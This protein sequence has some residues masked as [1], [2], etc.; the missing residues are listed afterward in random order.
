MDGEEILVELEEIK[1]PW[2]NAAEF[3]AGGY[4]LEIQATHLLFGGFFMA[5]L[6]INA[7]R[8]RNAPLEFRLSTLYFALT[9]Y[10]NFAYKIVG[11]NINEIFGILSTFILLAKGRTPIRMSSSMASRGLFILFIVSSLHNLAIGFAYPELLQDTSAV[12]LKMAVNI[13]IFI[14]AVNMSIVGSSIVRGIGLYRL[15]NTC[16]TAGII[17]QAMYLLQ[18]ALFV[19]GVTPYGTYIDAGFTGVP[20]FGSVSIERGHMGKFIAPY[21]AF[22]LYA[23]IEWKWRWKFA[24]F[25]IASA[26]NFSASG[27]VFFV[28]SII[29]TIIVFNRYIGA[30][31]YMLLGLTLT[32]ILCLIVIYYPVFDGMINKI[33][34]IAING[35]ESQ[36]GGRSFD[37]FLQYIDAYPLGIGYSGS[38]LRS[39]AGLP[40]INAAHFAFIT[41]Y[42]LLAVPIV[43]FFILLLI[44]ALRGGSLGDT[45]GRSMIVGTVMSP[46]IFFVDILWFVPLVW[47][48][49]EV[50]F[51]MK[52]RRR[53]Q[54]GS[55][56]PQVTFARKRA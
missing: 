19:V 49:I 18:V 43:F 9:V 53:K 12:I 24:L 8:D 31:G 40:E 35:D 55:S 22:F 13:K 11:L 7:C 6:V 34:T 28:S 48:P 50:I 15:I 27:L 30:K 42:S 38:S 21:F 56:C 36:G 39:L 17:A 37:L 1:Y 32:G 41:Q 45:L 16:I 29:T 3:W 25:L 26:I 2:E 52:T 20:S 14:L 44:N 4:W 5:W 54:L 33:F 23:F 47:L 10:T 46:I 51:S